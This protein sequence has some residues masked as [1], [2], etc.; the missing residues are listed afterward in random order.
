MVNKTIRRKANKMKQIYLAALAV[1]MG[2]APALAD[3]GF[4]VGSE[5]GVNVT[6]TLDM[7]GSSNDRASVCDEFI[8]PMFATVTKTPG[9]EDYNCTEPNRGQGDDWRNSFDGAKGI[10]TGAAIGYSRGR[11]RFELDYF[12]QPCCTD[13]DGNGILPFPSRS[14]RRCVRTQAVRARSLC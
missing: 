14:V 6:S 1:A 2:A 5:L 9:Y 8:N 7:V 13:R 12:Y 10:L 4:Y 11:L 3:S